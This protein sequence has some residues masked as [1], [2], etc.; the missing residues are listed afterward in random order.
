MLV[1]TNTSVDG[2]GIGGKGGIFSFGVAGTSVS[3]VLG[4]TPFHLEDH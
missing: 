4:F 3:V 1:V 2:I